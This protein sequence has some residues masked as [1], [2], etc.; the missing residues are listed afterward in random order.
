MLKITTTVLLTAAIVAGTASSGLAAKK[1]VIDVHGQPGDAYVLDE[2]GTAE[3]TGT[4]T[5]T[6]FDGAYTATLS[7]DDGS[8]P[9][10]GECEPATA[11]LHLAGSRNRYLDL[12]ASGEVCGT[13]VTETY[14]VTHVFTGRYVVTGA[15]ARRIV[16]TDGFLQQILATEGRAHAYAIDT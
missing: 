7:A 2:Q 14:Q 12:T 13:H 4:M 15:S 9:G 1:P 3:L 8:L 16:G 5:G 10:P 11:M 6:P